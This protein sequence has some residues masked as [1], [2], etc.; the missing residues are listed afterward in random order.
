MTTPQED[1]RNEQIRNQFAQRIQTYER[2]AVWML[3]E[4]L[5]KAQRA[6]AGVAPQGL[7]L[8]LDLCCGT[9]IVGRNLLDLGWKVKGLDLTPEM[10]WVAS[11]YFPVQIGSI[12]KLEIPDATYD[13][14]TLRQSFM[15][16]DG[17]KALREIHRVLKPGARFILIQ[18][19]SF[20]EGDEAVYQ[21][22]QNA[23]HINQ[24]T[25]YRAIDLENTFRD[26]GFKVADVKTLRVR[27]S[28]DHWLNSAPELKPEL[29]AKI[30]Q[31]I[32]GAPESYRRARDVRE[33]GGE[34]F[35]DWNWVVLTGQKE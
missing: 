7:D 1:P 3:N 15:L 21:Q 20:S 10:G 25:Y 11:Q 5:I 12:E 26:H 34:L 9:G 13:L 31:L 23:R 22:V 16:V 6:A 24:K 32:A 30:R 27:E 33:V 29:R 19:T 28:V 8:C 4:D 18:S 35:E 2:A 14:A 17:P